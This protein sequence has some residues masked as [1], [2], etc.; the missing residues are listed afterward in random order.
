MLRAH[1]VV[2]S[3]VE[4]TGD[5]LSTLPIADRATL[6]NMCPE[7]GATS[8]YFPIDEQT[9]AYLR[10]TGRADAADLTERYAKEQGLF[11]I[12]GDPEPAFTEV[13]E[14]DLSAVVPSLAGP[15]RPQDRVALKNV[16]AG[17][18]TALE[19]VGAQG[20]PDQGAVGPQDAVVVEADHVVEGLREPLLDRLDLRGPGLGVGAGPDGST[21]NA[22]LDVADLLVDARYGTGFTGALDGIA[23]RVA[24]RSREITTVAVDV[25]SGIDGLT[26]LAAGE[27]VVLFR[28]APLPPA[29]QGWKQGFQGEGYQMVRNAPSVDVPKVPAI[30]PTTGKRVSQ[31]V[32]T[33]DDVETMVDLVTRTE[34]GPFRPSSAS[35]SGV[36]PRT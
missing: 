16:K 17:F 4:F 25:P 32:L 24:R 29:P 13:L 33:D 26:G 2:G 30:D 7:Y 12:D 14:L 6:S 15:K 27:V 28:E 1:G 21:A 18:R 8:A 20:R 36:G 19:G 35:G 23:E 9:L 5:G 34:P 11:R 31:R 22:V 3:F 10:F